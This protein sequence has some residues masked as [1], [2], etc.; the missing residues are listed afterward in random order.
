[1]RPFLN[2]QLIDEFF[3]FEIKKIADKLIIHP[4][5]IIEFF[6]GHNRVIKIFAHFGFQVAK[7]SVEFGPVNIISYYH[8]VRPRII[9]VHKDSRYQNEFN[10][11]KL[12]YTPE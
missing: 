4:E 5:P 11:A 3:V 6:G 2:P 12:Q 1:M 7:K 9:E 10:L 8:Q